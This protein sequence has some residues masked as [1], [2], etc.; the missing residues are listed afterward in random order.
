[1][2]HYDTLCLRHRET[3]ALALALGLLLTSGCVTSGTYRLV[4]EERDEL[5]ESKVDL[6]QRVR[7]LTASNQ[8]LGAERLKLLDEMED[9]LQARSALEV[10]IRKLQRTEAILSGT[11]ILPPGEAKPCS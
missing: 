5:L 7:L 6:E 4:V 9:L 10:D 3:A 1:M 2:K 11:R 8:S